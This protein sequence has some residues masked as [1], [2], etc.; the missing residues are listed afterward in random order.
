MIAS[1]AWDR[2][3]SVYRWQ[4]PLE[5]RALATA[6]DLAAPAAGDRL[7]D[8]GTGTAPLLRLLANRPGAPRAAVGVDG[9]GAMLAAAPPLPPCWRLLRADAR[10]LPF[11]EDSFDVLTAAYL[12]HLL[13]ARQRRA[14]LEE[15]GR[16]LHT[17]ARLVV[18]TVDAPCS[19]FLAPAFGALAGIARRSSGI[20]SGMRPLDARP[21]LLAAGFHVRRARRTTRGYPSLVVLAEWRG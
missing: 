13:D 11:D 4:L 12:L 8:L 17:G 16:V 2:V 20:L 21:D 19:G 14:V 6:L 9:S 5:A 3:A 18:V 15:A 10:D 7:L 1:G